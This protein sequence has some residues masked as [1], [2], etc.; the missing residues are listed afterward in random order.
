M[1]DELYIISKELRATLFADYEVLHIYPI[2]PT[3]PVRM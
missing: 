1:N 2:A 3:P